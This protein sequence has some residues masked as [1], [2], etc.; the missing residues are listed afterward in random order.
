MKKPEKRKPYLYKHICYGGTSVALLDKIHNDV[1]LKCFAC[2]ECQ[3]QNKHESYLVKTDSIKHY[4]Q[5]IDDMD[6]FIDWALE[7]LKEAE[8]YKN[9]STDWYKNKAIQ[10]TLQ[11]FK[12]E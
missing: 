4:N 3:L 11:R 10:Q 1:F 2:K 6:S 12:G 7:P 9:T 8:K 5:A